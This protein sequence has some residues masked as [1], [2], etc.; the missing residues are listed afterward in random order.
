MKHTRVVLFYIAAAVMAVYARCAQILYLTEET[1]GFFKSESHSLALAL[2][3]FIIMA[4]LSAAAVAFFDERQPRRI[5]NPSPLLFWA[6][7]PLA[8]AFLYEFLFVKYVTDNA[9]FIILTNIFAVLSALSMIL[10]PVQ[11][12]F[13]Q[14]KKFFCVLY[15]FPLLFFLF[16]LI[17]VFTVYSTV[18]VIASNVFY[19]AFL[20]AALVFFLLVAKLENGLPVRSALLLPVGIICS[21]FSLC[22]FVPQI[23]AF[24]LSAQS[25]VH[26]NIHGVFL[27]GAVAIY[28]T[29]YTFSLYK[30]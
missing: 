11:K 24:A 28:S 7:I 18:S 1:S 25:Y 19:L 12:I 2:S 14:Y 8:V 3:V 5:D 4:A 23:I 22:C 9:L 10:L 16:K 29:V 17:C 6:G 26:D 30:K 13:P 21:I 20:S 15:T 27:C